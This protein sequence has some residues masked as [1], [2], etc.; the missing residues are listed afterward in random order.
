M[1]NRLALTLDNQKMSAVTGHLRV[2]CI[3]TRDLS[4]KFGFSWCG[5]WINSRSHK[6][7]Y[8]RAFFLLHLASCFCLHSSTIRLCVVSHSIKH[9][10]PQEFIIIILL[11]AGVWNILRLVTWWELIWHSSMSLTT[12]QRTST[13]ALLIVAGSQ[14]TE[15]AQH[16]QLWSRH[17]RFD[18]IYLI[19]S[20]SAD[21][22]QLDCH[23]LLQYGAH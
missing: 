19:G 7:S 11:I 1:L 5:T 8:L 22:A 23:M 2:E 6:S 14:V 9:T 12:N 17:Q 21:V 18:S 16:F 13:G 3:T 15:S 4:I 20:T 10:V